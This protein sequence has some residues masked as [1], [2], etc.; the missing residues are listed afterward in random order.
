MRMRMCVCVWEKKQVAE[1]ADIGGIDIDITY[2]GMS[3]SMVHALDGK[4][5]SLFGYNKGKKKGDHPR[6]LRI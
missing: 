2:K 5:N 3:M 1:S 6:R 4:M